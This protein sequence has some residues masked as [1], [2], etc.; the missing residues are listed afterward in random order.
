[1]RC[2][3]NKLVEHNSVNLELLNKSE[4][5]ENH[6]CKDKSATRDDKG[7][8]NRDADSAAASDADSNGK[9]KDE[10]EEK[11]SLTSRFH[12]FL[13]DEVLSISFNSSNVSKSKNLAD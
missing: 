7:R 9:D 6:F 3:Q 1:M 10:D 2:L 4:V 11:G 5:C 8:R 12:H 13:N